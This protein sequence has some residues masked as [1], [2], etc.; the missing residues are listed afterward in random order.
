MDLR[1]VWTTNCLRPSHRSMHW[2]NCQIESGLTDR[3][4]VSVG[5]TQQS[6]L[7]L[8]SDSKYFSRWL[9]VSALFQ[10]NVY[11]FNEV[12]FPP[13]SSPSSDCHEA[14]R[15]DCHPGKEHYLPVR[16][17]RKP[18]TCHILAERGQPGRKWGN[19]KAVAGYQFMDTYDKL[20]IMSDLMSTYMD[21]FVSQQASGWCPCFDFSK[22]YSIC[23]ML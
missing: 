8:K 14:Q 10:E 7:L 17:H 16:H 20:L 19:S 22:S 23:T 2:V 13:S 5:T 1:S 6:V 12:F 4:R 21:R 11:T 15:S 18:S 9:S 3:R